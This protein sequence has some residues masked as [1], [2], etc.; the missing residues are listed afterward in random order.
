LCS[1]P[2]EPA[3]YHARGVATAVHVGHPYFDELADRPL[4]ATFLAEQA[5]RNGALVAILPGSRTQELTRNLPDMIRAATKVAQ[6]SSGARFAVACLHERHKALAE[7]I[8]AQTLA[9]AGASRSGNRGLRR[10]HARIDPAGAS[11]V[12]RL[13]LGRA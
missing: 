13:G 7:H 3:W 1:L 8:I 4:D 10:T 2:F 6:K 9:R 11:R 12:G 5:E